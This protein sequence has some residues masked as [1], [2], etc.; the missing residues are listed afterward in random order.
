[1]Y[2]DH[3]LLIS[4]LTPTRRTYHTQGRPTAIAP[5]ENGVGEHNGRDDTCVAAKAIPPFFNA[6]AGVKRLG[7]RRDWRQ[8]EDAG[9]FYPPPPSSFTQNEGARIPLLPSS[10]IHSELIRTA[11]PKRSSVNPTAVFAIP[12]LRAHS[13]RSTQTKTVII[14]PPSSSCPHIAASLVTLAAQSSVIPTAVLLH[15][16][17]I[18]APFE[19][20][21]PA[22]GGVIPST[23][24]HCAHTLYLYYP[25]A[26][27][28]QLMQDA[29][30]AS[31]VRKSIDIFCLIHFFAPSYKIKCD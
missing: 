26:I 7:K 28:L 12:T 1:M 20:N 14:P 31:S 15:P 29:T 17:P 3:L 25:A 24:H 6:T 30:T 19:A 27:I 8:N 23:P 16:L 10:F 5:S 2:R 21:T 13:H 11:A 18:T 9:L 4:P 22:G